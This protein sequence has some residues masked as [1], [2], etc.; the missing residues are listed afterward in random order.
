MQGRLAPTVAFWA[1][2]ACSLAV[3]FIVFKDLADISQWLVQSSREFT[4]AVWYNRHALAVT[5]TGTLL[6]AWILWLRRRQ[7]C[8]KRLLIGLSALSLFLFYS[9]YV[10]PKLMFRSQQHDARFVPVAEARPYL[11]RSLPWARF[12]WQRYR[13]VDDISVIVL[14]TDRGAIAYSD[15]FLLQ[16][17]VAAGGTV[18][19]QPVV[20][21]YCGLTNLA[22]AY[23]PVLDGEPLDLGV[24]TQLQNNLVMWD[25][26]SGEPIQQILGRLE[27]AP[28]KGRM[29]EWPTVRMPFGT[30]A[31]LFPD[32]KV[33]V[34]EIP[35]FFE[36]P[37]LAVWDR[38]TRHVMMYN[39]VS[40]QWAR[41]APAF[42][43][44]DEFDERLPRKARIYGVRIDG[45]AVAYTREFIIEHGNAVNTVIGGKPV[46][47][48]YD[49]EHDA[50]GAFYNHT[51]EPVRAVDILGRTADG[52]TLERIEG[53]HNEA[54]WFIWAHFHPGADVNRT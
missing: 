50:V 24:M 31:E 36:N 52:E 5:A 39:G 37:I 34:N 9:G 21:T 1:L 43:T 51:G 11:E 17:H 26:N 38:L 12:G 23:S 48:A 13:S 16:P 46:V 8:P 6:G 35:G 2:M 25:R 3:S 4:M 40:L 10:N 41:E 19:G 15:Y 7:V 44:I 30:F 49:P 42:P 45:D 28:E 47:I 18:D 14:E 32:G 29:K 53:L 22:I 54:F 33:F 20:M 27:G